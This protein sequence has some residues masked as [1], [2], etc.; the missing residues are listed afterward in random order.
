[1]EWEEYGIKQSCV[2]LR[3]YSNIYVKM[4]F[5]N[6][7]INLRMDNTSPNR[8]SSPESPNGKAA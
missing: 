3:F 1:M 6:T 5:R 4:G 8:G 7:T 2:I